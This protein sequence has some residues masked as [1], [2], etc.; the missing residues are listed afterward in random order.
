MFLNRIRSGGDPCSSYA[1]CF[2]WW[3]LGGGGSSAVPKLWERIR[4][5]ASSGVF[6]SSVFT[7]ALC[8]VFSSCHRLNLFDSPA[9]NCK[10]PL[11]GRR[12]ISPPHNFVS[13]LLTLFGD[14]SPV[15]INVV[16]SSQSNFSGA[17]RGIYS[18]GEAMLE[19]HV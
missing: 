10:T 2:G 5:L 8:G 17:I 1:A 3:F 18:F 9:L 16:V 12:S 4:V 15:K 11:W 13:G 19:F 6:V 14:V 7:S